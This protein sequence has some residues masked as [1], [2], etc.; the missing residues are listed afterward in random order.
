M[1][2]ALEIETNNMIDHHILACDGSLHLCVE[3]R[4]VLGSWTKP[5]DCPSGL[6]YDTYEG[7]FYLTYTSRKQLSKSSE[8]NIRT[9]LL[10]GN[11]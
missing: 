5:R 2:G 8:E 10:W 11:S 9:L 6:H 7:T 4:R 3:C 1:V